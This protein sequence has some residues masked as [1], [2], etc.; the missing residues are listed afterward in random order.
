MGGGAPPQE[1]AC[2]K[3]ATEV[4][5]HSIVASL[6]SECRLPAGAI[7]DAGAFN[8]EWACYWAGIDRSRLV[9]A[10]DPDVAN[11]EYMKTTFSA[12]HP[13]LQPMV[14]LLGERTR[15]AAP[16]DPE[17]GAARNAFFG[18]E[19]IRTHNRSAA[20][21]SALRVPVFRVDDLLTPTRW[22]GERLALIHLDVEGERKHMHS[23]RFTLSQL[24]VQ[25]MFTPQAASLAHSEAQ[26]G[27][28]HS[29]GRWSSQRLLC[30]RSRSSVRTCSG[31]WPRVVTTPFSVRA[32][33]AAIGHSVESSFSR[34]C[35]H[36]HMCQ[37]PQYST[38]STTLHHPSRR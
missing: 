12:M 8:G 22:S 32:G 21:R 6:L 29:T 25:P 35:L 31:E 28:L 14:G 20:Y 30:T 1:A 3:P 17:L 33:R 38:H 23:K 18:G 13:N 7:L 27:R 15:V 37:Y 2:V 4:L 9:F 19:R 24:D 36:I 11:V 5:L 10:V 26:T 34:C 16:D